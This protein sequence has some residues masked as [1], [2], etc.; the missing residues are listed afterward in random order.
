MQEMRM[1]YKHLGIVARPQTLRNFVIKSPKIQHSPE[2]HETLNRV[3]TW[4]ICAMVNF[5][6]NLG[7]LLVQTSSNPELLTKKPRGSDR[8]RVTVVGET[9]SLPL[10]ALDFFSRDNIDQ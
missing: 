8:E 10:L 4:H 6:S 9:T 5:L 7:Q 1:N 3:M 2:I